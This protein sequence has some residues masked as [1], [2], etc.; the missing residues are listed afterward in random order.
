MAFINSPVAC[1]IAANFRHATPSQAD[2]K[3][4]QLV[5]SPN[6]S[7]CTWDMPGL[8][9]AQPSIAGTVWP[10]WTFLPDLGLPQTHTM[11]GDISCDTLPISSVYRSS[12]KAFDCIGI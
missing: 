11:R 10:F 6:G 5:M 2:S 9:V 12:A 7:W 4:S 8:G 3:K 1:A